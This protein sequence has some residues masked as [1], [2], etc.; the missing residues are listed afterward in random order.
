MKTLLIGADG[1]LGSDLKKV[2]PPDELIP[3]NRPDLDICDYAAVDDILAEHQPHI[4]IN[5]A[6]YH[7]VD[8]C[9]QYPDRA[10]QVN[11][12][13]IR[14]LSLACSKVGAVLVH[15]STDYV[16]D[17]ES[18]RPYTEQDAPRPLSAYAISKVAG[19]FFIRSLFDKY[20]LIRVCGLFGIAGSRG[21]GTNFIETMLKLAREGKKIKVVDDQVLTPT[22]T[23]A[24]APRIKALI[25]T[26][27]FGLY[28]MTCEGRC[29][30]YEFARAVFDLAGVNAD[31]APTASDQYYTPARRP[32]F[33][34]L[35]NEKLKRLPSIPPMPHWKDA[36]ADYLEERKHTR[37]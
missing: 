17:G 30:W 15:F 23:R 2:Y 28:H 34:V 36:L 14:N 7:R 32:R 25:E 26:G 6:A 20:F 12:L 24:L 16:F 22:Y 11:A 3:L 29:S 35:E 21:K 37:R 19:E 13:A 27:R 4:V 10:L 31:L 5:T 9:E 1:Q 33:S 8:E 18:D